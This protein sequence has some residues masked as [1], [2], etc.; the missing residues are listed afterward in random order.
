MAISRFAGAIALISA[1]SLAA[2]EPDD[3]S[4]SDFHSPRTAALGGAGH[5]GPLLN[6]ALYLNPAFG[7]FLPT[8][9]MSFNYMTFSGNPFASDT[10][11]VGN[12]GRNYNVSLHDG[13]RPNMFQAAVGYTVREDGA[14]V[15][16]GAAKSFL[17]RWGVGMTGKMFITG[18][19][20]K[21]SV[22]D[23][24]LSTAFIASSWL[25]VVAIGDNL[26]E[27]E[28][29]Q[30]RGLHR[31]FILGTKA[32]IMSIALVYFDPHIAPSLPAGQAFGHELGL[33]L[34]PFKDIYFRF[35][36]FRN[37]SLP[38]LGGTRGRGYSF[39]L[40]WLGPRLSID[41]A[42]MRVLETND[43][44]PPASSHHFGVTMYF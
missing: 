19:Q 16:L 34:T 32:N 4:A 43:S 3:A 6:D 12:Q 42:L 13:T 44:R 5:A 41:Y 37:A 20:E 1:V 29:G 18:G 21:R 23:F 27:T 8:Y 39:G 31:E 2:L 15:H 14:F 30:A 7:A 28:D 25:Q 35:G 11:V 33:E 22:T 38:H 10:P 26:L 40:G 9:S 17:E 24:M 36:N